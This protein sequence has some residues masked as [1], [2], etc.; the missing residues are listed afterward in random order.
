MT[1][2]ARVRLA[3]ST[4]EYVCIDRALDFTEH[5]GTKRMGFARFKRA[6]VVAG[7]VLA[8]AC[9]SGSGPRVPPTGGPE[10]GALHVPWKDKNHEERHA[11]MA[12]HVEP[13]MKKLFQEHNK[14]DYAGFGC[15]TCHG[16]D[17]ELVDYKMPNSL[18]ALPEKD[19]VEEAKSVDE[20]TAAFMV[21]KVLPTMSRLLSK[22]DG[23][24][25]PVSCFTCHPKE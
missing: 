20:D 7:A 9:S 15:P 14:K 10:I 4:S 5:R 16:K 3:G 17:A 1:E 18:Y 25:N 22:Q 2:R 24:G 11:Y 23:N 12:A 21:D 13:I 6:G 8:V 19:P